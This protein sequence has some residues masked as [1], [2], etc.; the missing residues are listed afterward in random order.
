MTEIPLTGRVALVTG[1]S[2]RS[3]IGFAIAN[4]LA[5]LGANLFLHS[6]S[7][8]DA[9]QPWGAD[10]C[11]VQSIVD[12]LRHHRHRVEHIESDFEERDSASRVVGAA[13]DAFGHID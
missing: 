2:R 7:P 10:D 5:S 3:G 1:V 8:Y 6:F 11:G 4:R 9:G 12:E 13:V